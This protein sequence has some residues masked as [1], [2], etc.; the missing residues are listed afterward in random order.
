MVAAGAGP[1]VGEED[2][3]AEFAGVAVLAGVEFPVNEDCLRYR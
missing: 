3:V 1:A 2:G